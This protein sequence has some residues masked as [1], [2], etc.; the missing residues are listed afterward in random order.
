M[1]QRNSETLQ[2]FKHT[3]CQESTSSISDSLAKIY[4]LL[5]SKGEDLTE[6]EVVYFLKQLESLG[7]KNPSFLYLKTSKGRSTRIMAKTSK[8][9]LKQLP[10]LGMM[11]NG[12]YLIQGGFFPKIESGY[13]L[14]D[15]LEDNVH[16][17]YSLSEQ[18]KKRVTTGKRRGKLLQQ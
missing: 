15:I 7:I 5:T 8:S 18:T 14:S 12:S 13:T 17:R 3:T 11:V 6:A 4:Q 9:S 2:L 10:T 16:Q 1:E